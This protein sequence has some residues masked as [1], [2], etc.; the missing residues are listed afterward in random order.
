MK[1][2]SPASFSVSE[3]FDKPATPIGGCGFCNGL[4]CGL[5]KPNIGSGLVTVQNLPWWVERRLIAP[6]P[7]D[8]IQRLARHLPVDPDM[9][10]T[11]NIAQSLGSPEAATPNIRRPSER[12]S[13]IAT[14]FA[15][16]AG[17]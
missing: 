12:W 7:Q 15:S 10:S 13:S 6:Q 4:R 11:L 16:S 3:F 17:W 14:R 8:D 1:P 5:R 2:R 9:P